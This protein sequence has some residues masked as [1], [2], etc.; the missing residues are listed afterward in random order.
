[1]KKIILLL[2]VLLISG[3]VAQAQ[4]ACMGNSC[5]PA[6]VQDDCTTMESNGCIDWTNGIIYA[7]GM[8][9]PNPDFKTQAQKRYSAYVAAQIVAKKNLLQMVQGIN[10]TS[11]STVKAGMLEN[12][13]INTQI[14]GKVKQVQEVGKPRE[15]NDGSVW[16]TMKMYLRDIMSVLI[17]NRQF[18]SGRQASSSNLGFIQQSAPLTKTE[19]TPQTTDQSDSE[20]QSSSG[21]QYGGDENTI[22]SGL[23]IDARKTGIVPAMSPKIYTPEG[24]E[25]YGSTA[26]DR[27]F[28]LSQ[29]IVGYVKD[30]DK[31]RDNDRVKGN[32]LMIKGSLSPGKS[33]DLTISSEDA[34]L[35]MKLD[36]TQTFLRE[37][38]VIIIL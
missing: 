10:I 20:V 7:T 11:T 37:A 2:S 19:K 25:I 26:V 6:A 24:K 34:E 4:Q 1:M 5:M 23:I 21:S 9:V 33:S 15:M 8:G 35:L 36:A 18:E 22:Y 38:R 29:G 12:E 13:V 31:A 17:N 3:G 27:D 16:V 14:S 28:V 32:P 30:L